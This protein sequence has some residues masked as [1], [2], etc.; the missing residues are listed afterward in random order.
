MTV[1]LSEDSER[2][3]TATP[4]VAAAILFI[5]ELALPVTLESVRSQVYEV[6]SVAIIGGGDIGRRLAEKADVTHADSLAIFVARLDTSIDY[7]WVIHGDVRPRPDALGALVAETERNEASLVGSKVLNAAAPDRLESVGAATD[8]FGEPYS[9]LDPD[10]VDLEQYDVVRDVAFI[11]GVSMLVRRDLIRGLRGLD[12]TLPPVA[13]GLDLSQRAR[14]AG[15]RVMVAPSSE[16][17]H[18]RACRHEGDGWRELAGRM[19]AML[20]AYRWLTLLWAVPIGWLVLLLDAVARLSLGRVGPMVDMAKASFWNLVRLPSTLASRSLVRAVRATGDEELFRYQVSGSVRLRNLGSDMASRFGWIIDQ[21]PGRVSE[22][23][24]EREVSL[25]GPIG[26]GVAA[27]LV[28]LATRALWLGGAPASGFWLPLGSSPASVLGSY[29]GGWN[30]SGLGSTESTHPVAALA[31]GVQWLLGGWVGAQSLLTLSS[32]VFGVWG[33]A[34]LLTRLGISGAARW[35]GGAV[36]VVGPF[37]RVF[38][39]NAYWPGFLA[40]GALPWLVDAVLSPADHTFRSIAG[41]VGRIALAAA[42]AGAPAPMAVVIPVV[43]VILAV[44]IMDKSKLR[45]SSLWWAVVAVVIGADLISPYLL[46]IPPSALNVDLLDGTSWPA[47]WWLG[48]LALAAVLSATFGSSLEARTAGWGGAL[49]AAGLL[50]VGMLPGEFEVA[51]MLLASLGAALVVGGAAHA[52]A[53]SGMVVRT[54]RGL[55]L[56]AAAVVVAS[57]IPAIVDGRI[58][59]TEDGWSER[60]AFVSELED[61]AG[62]ERALLV[63]DSLPGEVRS[64]QGYDFRLITGSRPTLDQAWLAGDRIGDR[65]LARTLIA[66]DGGVNARPGAAL[67]E[68]AI[69]WVVVADDAPLSEVLGPQVD[70][71]ERRRVEGWTVFE[72]LAFRPRVSGDGWVATRTAAS[73]PA[74]D[75]VVRLADN[76][77][78]GWQPGWTQDEWSNALSA[79]DGTITYRPDPLRQGLA[80]ASAGLLV[81]AAGLAFWGRAR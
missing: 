64:G 74:S 37:A 61:S 16:V 26:A 55:A 15:G 14:I 12:M 5:E 21:E 54:G 7:V 11:S 70:L 4:T 25:S 41:K 67:A 71:A 48:A 66:V 32:I 44:P 6:E 45:P 31:S 50:G 65:A 19:R 73:G 39:E 79:V 49:V 75:S 2:V 24:L 68:F 77:D 13:A 27:A 8:V 63:G 69:R 76:A 38:T 53:G 1:S 10:E 20:K 47:L 78:P 81:L 17:L 35:L 40:L 42:L 58:G 60:L 18:L 34:R 22:E 30:P 23:E 43:A 51:A 62:P 72:N 3:P 56:V 36:F 80:V 33:V 57:M 28:G 59:L 52:H 9:G 29:A 46:G